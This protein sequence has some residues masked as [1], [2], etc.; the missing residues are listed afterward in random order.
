MDESLT[1]GPLWPAEKTAPETGTALTAISEM[2]GLLRDTR[3]SVRLDGSVLGATIIGLALEVASATRALRPGE[4]GIVN[5]GLLC[6]LLAC[7]LRAGA[8]VAVAGRPV[9]SA[10]SELRW[11]TGAPLDP[12]ASW[13]T[14]PPAETAAGEWTWTR[15]HLLLGAA[16][17]ARYRVHRADTWTY[18]TAA[19]FLVWTAVIFLG[20]LSGKLR[21]LPGIC[22]RCRYHAADRIRS[23]VL[24]F[25]CS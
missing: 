21:L 9:L 2:T 14:V 17:L 1:S 23:A 16:R 7:W 12:A 3:G 22:D 6:G 8:L 25:A 18:L 11:R 20:M 19:A 5:A 13:L 24:A 10:L 15:A 4:T